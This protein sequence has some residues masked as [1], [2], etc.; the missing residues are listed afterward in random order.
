M[1]SIFSKISFVVFLLTF[2]NILTAKEIVIYPIFETESVFTKGDAADDPAFWFNE[3][4]PSQS[5]IFGTDKKAGLHSFSLTGK[6]IQYLP[7]GKVNNID[8][9][10]GYNF[11]AKKF[12]LLAASNASDNSIPVY[13]VD[14]NGIIDNLKNIIV[15]NLDS[16][17]G[18]CMYKSTKSNAT[19]I[20]VSDVNTSSIY[21]YRILDVFPIKVQMV[22]QINLNSTSEGCVADDETGFLYFAQEDDKSGVY[23]IDAEPNGVEI[24]IIDRTVQYGGNINGDTEG[25]AILKHEKMKLLIASSQGSSDFVV[26]NLD[27]NNQFLG[28][29]S[30]KKS[31]KIDGV[32]RTDGIEIFRGKIN[33]NFNSGIFIAQDDMNMEIYDLNNTPLQ[34][35][36]V[37]QNFKLMNLDLIIEKF[38][39]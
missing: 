39:D 5:K 37:N 13:L 3:N 30:I 36:Q 4:D 29:I 17:Y 34:A 9:R 32:S 38:I 31:K 35:K 18:L 24:Q 14:E 33:D 21:Q 22:R 26:Y 2:L 28:R 27:K 20:F 23:F 11:G 16:V 8:I 7:S 6:R 10:S 15:T 19:F 12:S 1:F 25:L